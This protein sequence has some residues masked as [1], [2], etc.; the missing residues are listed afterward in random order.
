M[1]GL[2]GELGA[3]RCILRRAGLL[4]TAAAAVKFRRQQVAGHGRTVWLGD[5]AE[6][7]LDRRPLAHLPGRLESDAD[8]VR[9][10]SPL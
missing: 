3:S 10:A 9:W 2:L 1:E 4:A 6:V 5:L 7:I 8:P